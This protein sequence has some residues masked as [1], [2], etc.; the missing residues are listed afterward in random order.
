M[1]RYRNTEERWV[2]ENGNRDISCYTDVIRLFG[3]CD[4]NYSSFLYMHVSKFFS[5]LHR[6]EHFNHSLTLLRIECGE[7]S[8]KRSTVCLSVYLFVYPIDRQQQRRAAGLLLS[9]V[10]TRDIDQQWR[11]P[12][13]SSNGASAR[14]WA[15]NA[16]S[17]MLTAEG[18]RWTQTGCI[19][20]RYFGLFT[21][22][23]SSH[24]YRNSQ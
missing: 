24:I 9:A 17:D 3:Y 5:Q 22:L 21:L 13:P 14:R 2:S 6:N 8:M 11:A 19:V 12:A 15:A 16:G 23:E 1:I 18:R 20:L 4:Q 7:G 10:R